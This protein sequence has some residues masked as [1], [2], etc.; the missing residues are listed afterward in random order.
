MRTISR[1]SAVEAG[2]TSA[3]EQPIV[4][5]CTA[6]ELV[7][8]LRGLE[9]L[10]RDLPTTHRQGAINEADLDEE[11]SLVPVDVLV[12]DLVGFELHDGDHRDLHWF[13]GRRDPGQKPVHADRV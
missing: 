2:Y 11:R 4:G 13:A 5:R 7:H 10:R 9:H 8:R 3:A 1:T 12:R 6:D